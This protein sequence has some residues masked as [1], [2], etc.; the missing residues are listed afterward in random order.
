MI[1]TKNTEPDSDDNGLNAPR[2]PDNHFQK[3]KKRFD[4]DT[5]SEVHASLPL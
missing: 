4:E 3:K 2:G 5:S 1:K